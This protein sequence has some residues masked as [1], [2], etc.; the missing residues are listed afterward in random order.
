MG[1]YDKIVQ[2]LN[3]DKLCK[4][5]SNYFGEKGVWSG[6]HF[7][8]SKET[9]DLNI[10][11]IDNLKTSLLQIGLDLDEVNNLTLDSLKF[12]CALNSKFIKDLKD[13]ETLNIEKKIEFPIIKGEGQYRCTK[14]YLDLIVHAKPKIKGLF[15]SYE[16]QE[17][18][19]FLIEVKKKEDLNDVGSIIRQIN[20][21][22]EYYKSYVCSL[23]S[24]KIIDNDGRKQKWCLVIDEFNEDY[25]EMFEDENIEIIDLSKELDA[26]KQEQ[27]PTIMGGGCP[28]YNKEV[29]ES[30]NQDQIIVHLA[31]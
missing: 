23:Y 1:K 18:I 9:G 27:V 16:N 6:F 12:K 25:R 17:P 3:K 20:E 11:E 22:R 2:E 26:I 14:G 29:V 28:E 4:L 8:L 30:K 13:N 24:S 21:Y 10:K 31:R 7:L 15:S 5:L 19:E